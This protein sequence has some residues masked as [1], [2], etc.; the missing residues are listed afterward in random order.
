AGRP[1]VMVGGLL[2]ALKAGGAYVPLDP[3]Y[4][5]ERLRFILADR[6]P[7]ALPTDAPAPRWPDGCRTG[8]ATAPYAGV[9]RRPD[10][11]PPSTLA[12]VICTSGS[13]GWPKGVMVEHRNAVASTFARS[14]V[15]PVPRR[16]LLASSFSFDSS[17]AGIFG[18]L[19]RG[20]TL[21]V[22]DA[23]SA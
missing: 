2:G 5:D 12:C 4:P 3:S 23:A 1:V 10:G 22:A 19:T 11:L 20:G 13:T 18:T 9:A 16:F 14:L 21:V 15:Y 7:G 8:L 17:V 6:G